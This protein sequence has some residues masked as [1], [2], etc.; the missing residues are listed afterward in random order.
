ML[1][2]TLRTRDFDELA[3]AFPRWVLCFQQFGRGP[4]RGQLQCLQQEG[5]LIFQL[6]ANRRF[7]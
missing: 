2:Q 6:A 5:T 4:F 7:T 3:G 1:Q